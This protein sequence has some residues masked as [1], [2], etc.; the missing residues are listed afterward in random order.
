MHDGSDSASERAAEARAAISRFE[1]IR[2]AVELVGD[3]NAPAVAQE[4]LKLCTTYCTNAAADE[5]KRRIPAAGKALQARLLAADGGGALLESVGFA[6]EGSAEA[7][8]YVCAL[9]AP[10]IALGVATLRKGEDFWRELAGAP[11]RRGWLGASACVGKRRRRRKRARG[12]LVAAAWVAAA[13]AGRRRGAAKVPAEAR[14]EARAETRAETR[15]ALAA[16]QRARPSLTPSRT[17]LSHACTPPPP[18]TARVA[19]A[20]F[21]DDGMPSGGSGSLDAAENEPMPQPIAT[22]DIKI[23]AL[24][25]GLEPGRRGKVDM[26]PALARSADR[27]R[28]ELHCWHPVSK[29]WR[30]VGSVRMAS[31]EFEWASDGKPAGA[32]SGAGT[33]PEMRVEVEVD[34]GDH[35][36]VWLGLQVDDSLQLTAAENEYIAAKRFIDSQFESL[37]NNHLEPIARKV[38]ALVLPLLDTIRNLKSAVEDQS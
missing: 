35:K 18:P 2:T 32:P 5:N 38:R 23:G 7:G 33:R 17:A 16:G 22:A 14:A 9:D 27:A 24:P 4:C 28:V 1:R 26:E 10:P 15:A 6:L 34:L 31:S 20:A 30:L 25:L 12:A 37:N 36:P 8:A 29:R 3:R 11:G 13:R 19:G 21:G